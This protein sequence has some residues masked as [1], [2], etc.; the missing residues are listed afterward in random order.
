MHR[1]LIRWLA[2]VIATGCGFTVTSPDGEG[3]G[4][5]AAI[6]DTSSGDTAIDGTPSPDAVPD[7]SFVGVTCPGSPCG[8]VCCEG[9]CLNSIASICSGKRYEC[10]GPEDCSGAE[11]CCNNQNGSTCTTSACNGSGQLEVCHSTTDCS[12]SCGNCSFDSAYGQN[13]CCE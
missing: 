13:V 2:L 6:V 10:D 11:V 4:S 1:E 3:T 7:A 12:F 5:D 9:T 8:S